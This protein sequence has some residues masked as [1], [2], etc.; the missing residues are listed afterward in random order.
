MREKNKIVVFTGGGTGGHIFPGLAIAD[1]LKSLDS[2]YSVVWL[3]SN[4]GTDKKNVL[5]SFGKDNTQIC[6]KFIAIPSGKLRRYFSFQ[7]FLDIFKIGFALI[8]A[9]F[10]LLKLK[11]EFVFSK[12]GFV[13]VPPCAAAKLLKIPVYTHECDFSPGLATKI[14]VKFAKKILVSYEETK[15]FFAPVVQQKVLVTGNP[16]RDIFFNTEKQIGLDFLNV[17]KSNKPILLVLGGSSGAHQVNEL[18]FDNLEWLVERFIVVHQTG[19]GDDFNFACEKLKTLHSGTYKPYDFIYS[20]MPHVLSCADIVVSRSGANSLWECV[21][22]EKPM[23]LVPLAG[24]GTRGDQ[25]EN[26]RFFEEKGAALVLNSSDT[27]E[28][29]GK[30]LRGLLEKTLDSALLENMKESL[31]QMTKENPAKQIAQFLVAGE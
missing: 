22:T 29:I 3:G 5:S 12:G 7:N 15:K 6:S 1:R 13:S 30:N 26:A 18:I 2:N 8:V 14:N 27:I 31:R 24:S 9:F 23:I 19:K 21:A 17:S 28:S 11:P 20:E 16:I 10:V 25:V 4:N